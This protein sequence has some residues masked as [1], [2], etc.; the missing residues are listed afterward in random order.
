MGEQY[1]SSHKSELRICIDPRD[2]NQARSSNY[3]R[4]YVPTSK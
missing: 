2:L 3:A 1:G 4:N